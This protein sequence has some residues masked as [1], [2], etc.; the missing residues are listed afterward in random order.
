MGLFNCYVIGGG[1]MNRSA[2]IKPMWLILV[3]SFFFCGCHFNVK[4]VSDIPSDFYIAVIRT[5]EQKQS[6]VISF[7]DKDLNYVGTKKLSYGM[8]GST[9]KHP[10]CNDNHLY[11]NA[12]GLGGE[13]NLGICLDMDLNT[14]NINELKHGLVGPADCVET[15]NYIFVCNNLNYKSHIVR[16]EKETGD[17]K[18]FT[19]NVSTIDT[20]YCYDEKLIAFATDYQGITKSY[21]YI[22]D[23]E[24]DVIRTI[25]IS[26]FGI[27]VENVCL[28][29]E[30]LLFNLAL[31]S[32]KNYIRKVG[33]LS[34]DNYTIDSIELTECQP[35]DLQ[36]HNDTL[37]VSDFSHDV[38]GKIEVYDL[39]A[40]K[41][42]VF[43][44]D[45][46]VDCFYLNNECLYTASDKT[47]YEYSINQEMLELKKKTEIDTSKEKD[48]HYYVSGIFFKVSIS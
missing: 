25:D 38:N 14:G 12:A 13:K 45:H 23:Y 10:I 11:V 24:F 32:S 15:D 43:Q 33:I 4:D 41:S 20:L 29:Q 42:K 47:L 8:V 31:D 9:W 46:T 1:I 2:W 34:L 27:N 5:T 39:K 21:I 3:L 35:L 18:E 37:Y 7:Y 17:I 16:C 22:M 28:Y 6:T 19:E 36:V 48:V 40:K 26:Q 30:K 44:L